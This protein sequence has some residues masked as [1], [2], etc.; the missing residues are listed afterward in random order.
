MQINRTRMLDDMRALAKFGKVETGVHRLSF[1]P[2]DLEARQ[3][4][5]QRMK[6]AGL[7]ARIDRTSW[8]QPGTGAASR[9]AK[10]LAEAT[11]CTE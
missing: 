10:R 9:P 6:D 8:S 11:G 5:L 3:W 4:L 2:E 7:D 1:T